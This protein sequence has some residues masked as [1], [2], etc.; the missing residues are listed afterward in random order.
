MSNGDKDKDSFVKK[1]WKQIKNDDSGKFTK[2][3]K[4]KAKEILEKD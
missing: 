2:E 3:D 4:E 1:G